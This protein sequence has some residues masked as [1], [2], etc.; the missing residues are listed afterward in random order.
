VNVGAASADGIGYMLDED[1]TQTQAVTVADVYA[2]G[3]ASFVPHASLEVD[4]RSAVGIE[5]PGPTGLG[6]RSGLD[7]LARAGSSASDPRL[8]APA[9]VPLQPSVVDEVAEE[10]RRQAGKK[11]QLSLESLLQ[12]RVWLLRLHP[13]EVVEL[14]MANLD[15][16]ANEFWPNEEAV[17]AATDGIHDKGEGEGE[18]DIEGGGSLLGAY[19]SGGSSGA[20][21]AALVKVPEALH[22]AHV[23]GGLD[24]VLRGET[25]GL[26]AL[27]RVTGGALAASEA[28][29][30]ARSG[31]ARGKGRGR[32]ML[33]GGAMD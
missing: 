17:E 9:S 14:V 5:G 12:D 8:A 15:V 32:P 29:D 7:A 2:R 11:Y 28:K 1:E 16:E 18:G 27:A 13:T 33:L 25:V 21:A 23:S 24:L 3:A 20:L 31:K 30:L 22:V 4:P 6:P 19:G 10:Q 26:E